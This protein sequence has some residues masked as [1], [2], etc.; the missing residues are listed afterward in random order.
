[1]P[2][3]R[4]RNGFLILDPNKIP[5][6]QY[7]KASLIHGVKYGKPCSINEMPPIDLAVVGSVAVSK[8]GFE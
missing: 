1:M 3:P 8:D 2:T 6:G 5:K 7:S 4:L